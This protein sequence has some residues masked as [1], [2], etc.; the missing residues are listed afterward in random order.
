MTSRGSHSAFAAYT[1]EGAAGSGG[2]DVVVGSSVVAGD[3]VAGGE[4]V[5]SV[6]AGAWVGVVVAGSVGG[7]GW[8]AAAGC[9]IN[10]IPT[11]AP[12]TANSPS[13]RRPP[14]RIAGVR[15]Y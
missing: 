12:T 14:L 4:V 1:T 2:W 3:V 9:D 10:V 13:P 7:G 11:T 8:V 6:V 15:R 5:G